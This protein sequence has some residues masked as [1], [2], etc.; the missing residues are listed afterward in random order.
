MTHSINRHCIG[1]HTRS[2][3]MTAWVK[4]A[5][6]FWVCELPSVLWHC[7]LGGSK[8]ILHVKNMGGWWRWALVIPDRV[9]PS[10]IFSVS[11]SVNLPLHHKVQKFSSGTGSPG[12]SRKKGRNMVV[13][14]C[15]F[16]WVTRKWQKLVTVWQYQETQV[17]ETAILAIV[18]V[19]TMW[20]HLH[21]AHML[22]K[23]RTTSHTFTNS[24]FHKIKNNCWMNNYLGV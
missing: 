24:H 8:G 21:T 1:H 3:H 10:P 18:L 15:V 4:P 22:P 9:A 12:C 13:C 7:S 14:V 16:L 20:K 23:D 17:L 19:L 5:T 11:A 6:S 2:Q